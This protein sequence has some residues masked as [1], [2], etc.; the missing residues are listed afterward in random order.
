MALYRRFNRS[1]F[2]LVLLVL[3]QTVSQKYYQCRKRKL[4][5]RARIKIIFQCSLNFRRLQNQS[6]YVNRSRL[7]QKFY[8]IHIR[9]IGPILWKYDK[10]KWSFK[11]KKFPPSL[12]RRRNLLEKSL[13]CVVLCERHLKVLFGNHWSVF[14]HEFQSIIAWTHMKN[15][16]NLSVLAA[17][18]SR[19]LRHVNTGKHSMTSQDRHLE[20]QRDLNQKRLWP[21]FARLLEQFHVFGRQHKRYLLIFLDSKRQ[22]EGFKRMLRSLLRP[23]GTES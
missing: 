5:V 13:V 6:Q 17:S 18:F 9:L 3:E 23:G 20:Y 2:L 21:G 12:N 1:D 8:F 19:E 14:S 4:S 15:N 10:P 16:E 7:Q 22:T 11:K